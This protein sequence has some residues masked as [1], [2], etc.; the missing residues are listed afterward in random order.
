MRTSGN[1]L[2]KWALLILALALGLKAAII[3]AD[4]V[5]FN[6]DEAVVALMAR[7]ILQGSRPI[8]FYGQAYMGSLDAYL[9][10][11][12]FAI[13]G[14]HV[15]VIRL[16]QSI[17]YAGVLMTTICIGRE[18]FASWRVGI[19]ASLLL[20]IP[21]VN[22][23][24]YTTV[25]LGGYAE[26]LLIGN[27][28]LLLGMRICRAFADQQLSPWQYWLTLG[29]LAGLGLWAFGLS[30]VY[31]LPVIG[32]IL[33][34]L[35]RWLRAEGKAA[36]WRTAS[37]LA[38]LF[39]GALL[40][41][42]PWLVFAQAHGVHSLLFELGGGAISGVEKIPWIFAVGRHL[43]SFLLLGLTVIFG[44]RPPWDVNWL[45]LPLIPF[46]LIFWMA[47][48]IYI[49]TIRKKEDTNR[50]N[51]GLLVGVMLTLLAGFLLTPFG[52]DPSGR[53]FLPLA[54]PLSLFA[55]ALILEAVQRWG[56]WG[57][58]LAALLL[59]YHLWGTIQSAQRFPPGLTTQ[60]YAPS[61]IDHRAMPELID[62][63]LEHDARYG[64]T[65]YWVSYPL[66][67]LSGE[68]IIYTPRLPYHLD[69]RY[70]ERYDRYLPYRQ[71]VLA[72][73]KVAYITTHHPE[74]DRYLR[75]AFARLN[76]NWSERKIGDYQVFYDLSRPVRPEEIGLGMNFEPQERP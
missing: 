22:V 73:Q 58:S 36:F 31:S 15:W 16:V 35:Y 64:Y 7:H 70:T 32:Y 39:G 47:V 65:N 28:I 61:Q 20:A 4:R 26:A 6:A 1:G 49:G 51:W 76:V 44:F 17:L 75:E 13:F 23:T 56:R 45:G 3:L 67:F 68:E 12:G 59:I 34:R 60:F 46:I 57:Y 50:V 14:Q 74:L 5:P 66:A 29:F 37:A 69:F 55:A 33:L 24:L 43:V 54:M 25:S 10:A 27:L 52:A 48:L 38:L 62:F 40:G 71:Q 9:V 8:F 18:A 42:A 19:L 30:L 53:Y 63:L 11:G 2:W 72:A 21:T 41:A